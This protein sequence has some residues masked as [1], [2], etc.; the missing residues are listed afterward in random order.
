MRSPRYGVIV[1]S[2]Y[3]AYPAN[4]RD[5]GIGSRLVGKVLA[6]IDRQGLRLIPRCSFV[7]GYIRKNPRWERIVARE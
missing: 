5:G 3:R 2:T 7:A 1:L 6:D 4:R